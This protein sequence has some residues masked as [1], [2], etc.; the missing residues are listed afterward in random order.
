MHR[1]TEP[2]RQKVPIKYSFTRSFLLLTRD[3]HTH[4]KVTTA[5][6]VI[7]PGTGLFVVSYSTDLPFASST[8]DAGSRNERVLSSFVAAL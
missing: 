6:F 5:D 4:A 3:S 1:T 8:A 7:Y 2:G